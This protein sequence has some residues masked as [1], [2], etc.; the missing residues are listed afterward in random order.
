MAKQLV[1]ATRN[2]GKLK[3][4]RAMLEP[5]G[6]D[7]LGIDDI[8]ASLPD[9]VEDADTFAG[10]AL[11][12]AR[13][14]A[15]A[16]GMAVVSDDSGLCVD[17]LGGAPGVYSARYA[18][19][20]ANDEANLVKLLDTLQGGTSTA[21]YVCVLAYVDGG[22]EKVVRGEC[23]GAIIAERRGDG[24]FGYDPVFYVA[25]YERTMAE[26]TMDEKNAISHRARALEQ[27]R[28]SLV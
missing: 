1:V 12:K 7:V 16:L 6:F 4:F 18:G 20:G 2:K 25:Q 15:S 11:K 23:E 27:L 5:I 17:A 24:G 21:R 8:D 14:F 22:Q 10:N 9:V 19:E 28:A 26:L 13:A 3:E